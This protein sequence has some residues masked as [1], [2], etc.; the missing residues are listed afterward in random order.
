MTQIYFKVAGVT[1]EGRQDIIAEMIEGQVVELV[2][3]PENVFDPN[4]IA[5]YCCWPETEDFRREK[6][7]FVPASKTPEI[8]A[9]MEQ[10][11]TKGVVDEITGGFMVSAGEKAAMGVVVRLGGVV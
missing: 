7:G 5:V 6:I 10:G 4:A 9:K 3:E 8:K 11:D 2:P 1:F